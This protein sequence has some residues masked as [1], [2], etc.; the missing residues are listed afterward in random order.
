MVRYRGNIADYSDRYVEE[1]R[2][3]IVNCKQLQDK[4]TQLC[5]HS[6]KFKRL[7]WGRPLNVESRGQGSQSNYFDIYEFMGEDQDA[8]AAREEGDKTE[9]VEESR[10]G[11][12]CGAITPVRS[13]LPHSPGREGTRCRRRAAWMEG[14]QEYRSDQI[15][16]RGAR[17]SPRGVREITPPPLMATS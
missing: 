17:S 10:R 3:P 9:L 4:P 2:E 5:G 6:F 13:P 7:E 15:H 12:R 16:C 14:N 8:A 1:E 11:S